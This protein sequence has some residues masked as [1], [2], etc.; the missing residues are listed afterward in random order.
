MTR[1]DALSRI[2]Q[3]LLCLESCVEFFSGSDPLLAAC[4]ED[5][6]RALKPVR[7][8]VF[9]SLHEDKPLYHLVSS[10]ERTGRE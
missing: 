8:L 10:V 9:N 6:L 7:Q 1:N 4:C 5:S 2:D 3:T